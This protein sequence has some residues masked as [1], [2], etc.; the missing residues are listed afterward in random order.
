LIAGIC[1]PG[2]QTPYV[3]RK[4]EGAMQRRS[5]TIR[6]HTCEQ[7]TGYLRG[8]S[9]GHKT[10]VRRVSCVPTLIHG[11]SNMAS[12]IYRKK[13]NQYRKRILPALTYGVNPLSSGALFCGDV[14]PY[15]ENR[16][17]GK[18]HSQ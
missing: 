2:H 12:S 4:T 9:E 18:R 10:K 11:N 3:K 1:K 13:R 17:T 8:M 14:V 16:G 6:S 15:S 5:K 7:W